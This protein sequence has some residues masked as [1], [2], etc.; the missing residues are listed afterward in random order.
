MDNAPCPCFAISRKRNNK[1]AYG[2]PKWDILSAGSTAT[3]AATAHL[4]F[5]NITG[6]STVNNEEVV[7]LQIYASAFGVRLWNSTVSNNIGYRIDTN[8]TVEWPAM[9]AGTASLLHIANDTASANASINWTIFTRS[10]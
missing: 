1:M 5:G 6:L 9:R 10:P 2:D 4:L 3:S 8:T 7:H